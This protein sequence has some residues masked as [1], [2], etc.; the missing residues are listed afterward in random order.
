MRYVR[1]YRDLALVKK[2]LLPIAL[3]LLFLLVFG[4]ATLVYRDTRAA[5]LGMART[6]LLNQVELVA[7]HLADHAQLAIAEG[8]AAGA[9]TAFLYH[10]GRDELA[11]ILVPGGATRATIIDRDGNLIA[12]M[13]GADNVTSAAYKQP[14]IL[15]GLR[16]GQNG[17]AELTLPG[18][19]VT[20]VAYGPVPGLDWGIVLEQSRAVALAPLARTGR[21]LFGSMTLLYG[22]LSVAAVAAARSHRRNVSLLRQVQQYSADLAV[23]VERAQAAERAKSAFMVSIGHEFRTPLTNIIA[24]TDLLARGKPEK[25]ELYQN[26][27]REETRHLQSLV[28]T[29]L[30]LTALEGGEVKL[31]FTPTDLNTLVSD[32]VC[33]RTQRADQYKLAL[34]VEL[35]PDLPRIAA[36]PLWLG[37]AIQV[38]LDNALTYTPAGGRIT[39]R[40]AALAGGLSA[41]VSDTGPGIPPEE[42]AH[43]FERFYRGA[44]Q[45]SGHIRGI[46]LGLAICHEVIAQHTGHVT[47]TSKVGE[48]SCFIIWLPVLTET[49]PAVVSAAAVSPALQMPVGRQ[50]AAQLSM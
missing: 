39:L 43:V 38:L 21:L 11:L 29:V 45:G 41:S 4:V 33:G 31:K 14:A 19:G 35:A 27:L 20:L 34:D 3:A 36:D 50:L 17:V 48:G 7:L 26:V 15:A 42:Q 28:L 47:L 16:Q 13:S 46:G 22:L 23:Q 8:Q 32:L 24:Y 9:L 2:N 6:L 37:R 5:Q 10:R 49:R 18:R 12:A 1:R 44:A 30:D 40:T 25:R